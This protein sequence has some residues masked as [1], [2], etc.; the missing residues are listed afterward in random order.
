MA[1]FQ[2]VRRLGYDPLFE[3]RE[4]WEEIVDRNKEMHLKKFPDLED[5]IEEAYALVYEKKILPSMRSMQFAGKPIEI[6][7]ARM[8]NC[9]YQPID[10]YRAFSEGMF[11]LLSGVGYGYSV[12]IHHVEKLPE[13]KKPT[14]ER[15][16]LIGDSIEGW[17]DAVKTLIKA[18]LVGTSRPNFDFSD[19]R[20]KGMRLITSGGK[21]P[22]PEP[23]KK[24]LFE[25]QLIL[26]RKEQG[27]KL[28]PLDCHDIMCHIAD[29]VLAGGIRRS[30]MISLFSF[31][32]EEMLTCKYG[33]WWELNPQRGRANNSAVVLSSRVVETDFWDIWKK[34]EHSNAGEPGLYFTNDVEYGTNP[35]VETS[36][37]PHT[38]C[39]LVEVN[40]SSV[41]DFTD[42]AERC[43][44]AARINT[45]QASYT[46]FHYLRDCWKRNTEKDSLIGV[47]IT[48]IASN[49][50]DKDWLDVAATLVKYENSRVSK[51]IGIK[52][53]A[54]CTVIKPSGTTSLVLGTSSGIHA[55]H[56][57]TYLRRIRVGKAE[58]IYSYLQI[59]HPE[60]LEDDLGKP[61]EVAIIT[62]P[63]KTPPGSIH[64]DE[65]ALDF[66]ERIKLYNQRWVRHGH[67]NGPNY[68]NVSATISIKSD[69]WERVGNWIWANRNSFHGL[70]VM[71][72]DGGSYS[73][74]P[75][76]DCT[77]EEYETLAKTLHELDLTKV[78]ELQDDTNLKGEIA[79]GPS[80]CEIT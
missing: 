28:T 65:D 68:H 37:R 36:L 40:G 20:Q 2:R 79:C 42:F 71:P 21:A 54:R 10:D 62:I 46:N 4:V 53:A 23:L 26:D 12:Q 1:N 14:K 60:I 44:M 5:E 25:I 17:S 35:C 43:T 47:G 55:W 57:E 16:Y 48:G 38:F 7:P 9:S 58:S 80:G 74:T 72:F 52:P 77:E 34:I 73:Q 33:N 64:R 69:E 32:D 76:E 27:S 63:Q 30:A 19:I 29:A 66:L 61:N 24:C 15:R 67:R 75:F 31:D 78:I 45:L 56:N 51:L 13:I 8:F 49:S 18:Y 41:S 59:Y 70:S 11:L 50:I 39:N 22:G 3:R 6:N